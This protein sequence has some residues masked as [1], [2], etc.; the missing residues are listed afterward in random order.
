[1]VLALQANIANETQI[2]QTVVDAVVNKLGYAGAILTTLE[3]DNTLPV[4]AYAFDVPFEVVKGIE[5]NAGVNLT[6]PDVGV[7]LD[8][9]TCQNNL[10]VR[11]IRNV[12]NGQ[13][14]N[15]AVS[16]QLYDLLRPV[17]DKPLLDTAQ[18]LI[19]VKQVIALPFF[20]ENEV[21][22]NLFV[23]SH[24][25]K[26]SEREIY[27]LTTFA[28]QAAVG[29]RNA[30]LYQKAEERRQIAQMFG[31]MAFGSA[32]NVHALR[33]HLGA[34]RTFLSLVEL[35]PHLSPEQQKELLDSS[36]DIKNHLNRAT[37]ILDNLH[38]P[39]RQT[40]DV[41]T[42]VNNCLIWA[43]RKI[44]PSITLDMSKGKVQVEENVAIHKLLNQ[45]L[46]MIKTSP[47]M[48]TEAFKIIIKNAIEAVKEKAEA[49]GETF[50]GQLWLQT[51][52]V[53]ETTLEVII[54]DNAM[55][56][57]LQ[58]LSKI[59]EM[60]WSTKEGTGMGFGLFWTKDY[61]EG[62]NGEIKVESIWQ[63]ET[64]FSIRLPYK[65]QQPDD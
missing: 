30:R 64:T 44:Y 16:D 59:F 17:I 65:T 51:R 22:G 13:L 38:E 37:D 39:W 26:F 9:E 15:F 50:E 35:L 4:R 42:E 60:G 19:G 3:A 46:P 55:G 32:A 12:V 54:R 53:D 56:I 27:L 25:P 18:Q 45:N 14:E 5:K 47:D 11:A 31:R 20:L 29:I 23:A 28:Q 34:V 33:N 63:E 7:S 61:I 10:G 36:L 49:V 1:V 6:D 40:P 62:L 21:V 52:L 2:L 43:V 24:K 48:M 58:D 8:D 41:P 57:N